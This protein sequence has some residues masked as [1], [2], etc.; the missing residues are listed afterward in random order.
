MKY[1]TQTTNSQQYFNYD[2]NDKQGFI[3]LKLPDNKEYVIPTTQPKDDLI[4]QF[5]MLFT[6]THPMFYLNEAYR[7]VD[8]RDITPTVYIGNDASESYT[9][10]VEMFPDRVINTLKAFTP[11]HNSKMI[12]QL[13]T[14][15]RKVKRHEDMSLTLEDKSYEIQTFQTISEVAYHYNTST[16]L[17]YNA[18]SRQ[19][20]IFNGILQYID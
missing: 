11:K 19:S 16:K 7:T 13:W 8:Y 17:I 2:T 4:H 18:I 3:S 12:K 15:P 6:Y 9:N 14:Y 20:K 5:N 1:I 10:Y